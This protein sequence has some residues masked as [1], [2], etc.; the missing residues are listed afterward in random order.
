[1]FNSQKDVERIEKLL[2]EG[3][4]HEAIVDID[5]H[6]TLGGEPWK[7]SIEATKGLS[8]IEAWERIEAADLMMLLSLISTDEQMLHGYLRRFISTVC[9]LHDFKGDYAILIESTV[10]ML[11]FGEH[12]QQFIDSFKALYMHH[13]GH[14]LQALGRPDSLDKAEL[15]TAVSI[16]NLGPMWRA[17]AAG[18]TQADKVFDLLRRTTHMIVSLHAL[19]AHGE[20]FTDMHQKSNK[21]FCDHMRKEFP[22]LTAKR[23]ANGKVIW[24]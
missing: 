6:T 14:V 11:T 2:S 1:M 15:L 8:G 23:D 12:P 16:T 19:K 7:S 5:S 3:R 10:M 18:L 13:M 9:R 24:N 21:V 4:V 20:Q 17:F 22:L